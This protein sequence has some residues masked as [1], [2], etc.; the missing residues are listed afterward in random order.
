MPALQVTGEGSRSRTGIRRM[1]MGG[2][3]S[4]PG[5]R[6]ICKVGERLGMAE[7]AKLENMFV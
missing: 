3:V 4:A 1:G 2:P 6:G 5:C 7:P